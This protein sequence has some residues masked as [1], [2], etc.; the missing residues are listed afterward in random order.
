MTDFMQSF[1]RGDLDGAILAASLL[2]AGSIVL[3]FVTKDLFRGTA[4]LENR[5]RWKSRYSPSGW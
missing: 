5:V 2:R 3:G 4:K 1:P